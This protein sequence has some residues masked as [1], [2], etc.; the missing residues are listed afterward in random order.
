MEGVKMF[1]DDELRQGGALTPNDQVQFVE[2]DLKEGL[3]GMVRAL[4]GDVEMRWGVDFFPFTDPS[5]ELE[6]YFNDQWLE[7]LGCG[8]VHKDIVK[9]V[10]RGEQHGW[11]FG[12]G[13][14]RLAM[15]LFSIPDIRL[16][17]SQDERFHRQFKSGSIITFQPYSKYPPCLKDISFWTNV[18]GFESTFHVNDLNEVIRNIAGDL[19]EQVELIDEFV[20]PKS[21]RTSNCFRISYRSMDRSLT[22][23]EIDSIQE[24]VRDEVVGK[25]GVDLR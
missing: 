21:G 6:I 20:H 13:L 19:V 8:V 7:V 17:W 23:E 12:L 5:F 9:A 24:K 1:S 14:E 2:N 16:F 4:F 22:N 15:I 18:D 25:L 3:E 11:A 10:G